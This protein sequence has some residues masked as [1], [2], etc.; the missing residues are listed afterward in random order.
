VFQFPPQGRRWTEDPSR[1][2]GA[3]A[4]FL[5]S[6]PTG[7]TYCVELRDRELFGSAYVEA[8]L[9]GGGSHCIS[10]HPRMPSAVEQH[11]VAAPAIGARL[12]VRWMLHAGM[13]YEQA[14]ERYE[15]FSE[16]VDEDPETRSALAGICRTRAAR[17]LETIVIVNNKAEGSAPLSAFRL[18][19]EIIVPGG[20]A[21]DR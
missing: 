2:A 18:A 1:F 5:G 3:L 7:P 4:A 9:A 21:G 12:V 20:A 19:E 10:V 11:G 6:L 17:G 14:K 16:L 8:L 13:A 15:P